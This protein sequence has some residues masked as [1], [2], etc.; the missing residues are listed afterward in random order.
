MSGGF[1]FVAR[2]GG[3]DELFD[4]FLI[5]ALEQFANP[6]VLGT[7]GIERA[8]VPPAKRDSAP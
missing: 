3:E 7:D 6:D 4:L 2:V 5:D 8:P 1:A